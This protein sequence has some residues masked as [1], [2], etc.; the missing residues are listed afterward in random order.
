MPITQATTLVADA[1]SVATLPGTSTLTTATTT[2]VDDAAPLSSSSLES[3]SGPNRVSFGTMLGHEMH[4]VQARVAVA[5]AEAEAGIR[6]TAHGRDVHLAAAHPAMAVEPQV[7]PDAA[8]SSRSL[9]V[10]ATAQAEPAAAS[11][12]S[13][14]FA[15]ARDSLNEFSGGDH[16]FFATEPVNDEYEPE[17]PRGRLYTRL[18]VSGAVVAVVS[19]VVVAWVNSHGS[20]GEER[21]PIE[22][23]SQPAVTAPAPVRTA[24]APPAPPVRAA[25]VP[26]TSTIPSSMPERIAVTTP[27]PP[28]HPAKATAAAPSLAPP[29]PAP[30]PRAAPVAAAAAKPA[31]VAAPAPRPAPVAAAAA[32]KLAPVAAAA[33][34][35]K[36]APVAAAPAPKPAPAAAPP[37]AAPKP[38]PVAAAAAPV[39]ELRTPPPPPKKPAAVATA[40]AH[41]AATAAPRAATPAPPPAPAARPAVSVAKAPTPP[42]HPVAK[43]TPAR[44]S[45][46]PARTKQKYDP[47]GTLPL[48]FE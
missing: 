12:S 33:L 23:K 21:P 5:V 30:P 35:P 19:V 2:M 44:A 13:A 27:P 42:S 22:V 24:V 4:G 43:S 18:A 20:S 3:R 26:P 25:E 8:T 46:P 11:T 17:N 9:G 41:P 6:G 31:P 34:A 28:P 40:A 38:A 10:P 36:P 1:P 15:P 47:D 48:S 37:A 32:P 29:A 7:V 45:K 16:N 39:R 14:K